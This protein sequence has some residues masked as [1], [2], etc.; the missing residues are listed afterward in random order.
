M[1]NRAY[2]S[3]CMDR[4]ADYLQSS[5]ANPSRY[6]RPIHLRIIRLALRKKG[7]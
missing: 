5:L 7:F 4:T 3:V 1:T 2:L 6:M